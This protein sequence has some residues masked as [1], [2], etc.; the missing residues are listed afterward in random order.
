MLYAPEHLIRSGSPAAE[1]FLD[2]VMKFRTAVAFEA[3]RNCKLVIRAT[4]INDGAHGAAL[5]ALRHFFQLEPK[6]QAIDTRS[7]R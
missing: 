4:G 7:V 2:Q 3:Y 5:A 1:A 6:A